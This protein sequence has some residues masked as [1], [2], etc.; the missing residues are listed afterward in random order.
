MLNF[1]GA[2]GFISL[3]LGVQPTVYARHSAVCLHTSGRFSAAACSAYLPL[4]CSPGPPSSLQPRPPRY[5]LS[6]LLLVCFRFDL[7]LSSLFYASLTSKSAVTTHALSPPSA[8]Q[9]GAIECDD[10]IE[11]FRAFH[12]VCLAYSCVGCAASLGLVKVVVAQRN[13]NHRR[14]LG[15][16]LK[17]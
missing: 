14:S 9:E 2:C 3:S 4:P 17:A 10:G 16:P 7:L 13:S 5:F 11:C 15:L 6:L 12:L 8:S 1:F